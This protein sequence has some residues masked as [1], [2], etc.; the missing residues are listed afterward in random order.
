MLKT[1]LKEINYPTH[2]E[3]LKRTKSSGKVKV[4]ACSSKMDM[5]GIPKDAL[6][7]EV[8]QIAGS[9]VVLDI[10]ADTDISLLI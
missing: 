5:L 3:M 7:P 2:Y 1:K 10:A 9:A 8:D 4:Y 6:I